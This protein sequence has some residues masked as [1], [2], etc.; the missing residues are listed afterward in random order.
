MHGVLSVVTLI[1]NSLLEADKVREERQTGAGDQPKT[2]TLDEVMAQAGLRLPGLEEMLVQL[3]GGGDEGRK[4]ASLIANNPDPSG[5]LQRFAEYFS[6]GSA[7]NPGPIVA[8]APNAW[9]TPAAAVP[10]GGDAPKFRPEFTRQGR[11][12]VRVAA[13]APAAA[14]S[15][16][17]SHPADGTSAS[18]EVG[19][20]ATPAPTP[21]SSLVGVVKA[22]LELL[23]RRAKAHEVEL[24]E[25]L[26]RAEAE[27]ADLR[28]MIGELA[29]AR[30]ETSEQQAEPT[31]A[32]A[33]PD[34]AAIPD[35]ADDPFENEFV[36]E[37]STEVAGALPAASDEEAI[38]AIRLVAEF[39]DEI[40]ARHGREI[41]RVTAV[42]RSVAELRILLHETR[43]NRG[44]SEVHG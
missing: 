36:G 39:G 22:Q 34:V 12:A 37:S 1:A 31:A 35:V 44:S 38:Q 7:E 26:A 2:G 18:A 10:T 3:M 43:V 8:P 15:S 5:L 9:T 29:A 14:T 32:P 23:R 19:V 40:E 17:R 41:A 4:A 6:R 28:V 30:N 25:R 24:G 13:N 11:A 21:G 20:A 42:E 33:Y 16:H 27:L